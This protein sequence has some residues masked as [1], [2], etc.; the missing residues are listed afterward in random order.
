MNEKSFEQRTAE[1]VRLEILRILCRAPGY[2]APEA[3]VRD[4]LAARYG[5]RI[6]GARMAAEAALLHE[7]LLLTRR[8][9]GMTAVL[10]LT[11]RGSD[12]ARGDAEAPGVAR[13]VPGAP[14]PEDE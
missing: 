12:V 3:Q 2:T 1:A 4:E 13:P 5:H 10:V 14:A 6:G 11:P 9:V 7:G 8:P